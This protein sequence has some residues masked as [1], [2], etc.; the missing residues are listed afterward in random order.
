[1]DIYLTKKSTGDRLRIPL[2]PD[3]FNVKTN[4][5]A[6]TFNVIN[7]GELKIPRGTGIKSYQWNGILPGKGMANASF[8][9]D[10][11][12]PTT[13]IALLE[14]W[15]A[16]GEIL[17]LMVTETNINADVFIESMTYE[18]F[19]VDSVSYTLILST[20]K[21]LYI[22]IVPPPV[23]Q[24]PAKTEEPKYQTGTINHKKTKYRSGPGS[25][26]K[27]LGRLDKGTVVTL[28][29]KKDNWYKVNL[30][31]E[32]WVQA[33][34]ITVGDSTTKKTSSSSKSSSKKKS[35][36]SSSSGKKSNS[37]ST[38]KSNTTTTNSTTTL[39]LNSPNRTKI[40]VATTSSV[41]ITRA[42][43]MKIK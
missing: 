20:Y 41:K 22:E 42:G 21:E 24:K 39:T 35:S 19:G 27:R 7:T 37:T 12:K 11:Q 18:H 15:E 29:E 34:Y 16:A 8:V 3:R 40:S 25:K 10:W 5:A 36:S 32:W 13:I 23:V 30:D 1:M 14:Q 28:Y 2:L 38:T 6:L 43:T 26:Y 31:P 33:T 17:R 4:A 9:H